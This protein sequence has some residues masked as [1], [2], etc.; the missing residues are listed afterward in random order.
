[1]KIAFATED[2]KTISKHFGRAPYYLVIAIEDGQE[3]A[4]E[5]RDKM[6]HA[7]VAH[8][9][10]ADNTLTLHPHGFS[11]EEQNRHF[12]MAASISDCTAL[13]CGGMGNGAYINLKQCG[14]TPILTNVDAID[15]ALRAYLGG[16]LED[17]SAQMLH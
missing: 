12:Q 2:G 9:A 3:T 16:T 1:M 17:R 6:N 13:V 14:I 10:H 11:P 5:M 8:E 15:D 4:R 7:H